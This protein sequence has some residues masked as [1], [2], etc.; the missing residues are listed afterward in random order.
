MK[1]SALSHLCLRRAARIAV[2]SLHDL[3]ETIDNLSDA[4]YQDLVDNA[5]RVGQKSRSLL[6]DGLKAFII[7]QKKSDGFFLVFKN[8]TNFKNSRRIKLFIAEN[9]GKMINV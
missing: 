5:K 7:D 1:Q 2:E 8:I 4:D 6:K 9:R 3:K